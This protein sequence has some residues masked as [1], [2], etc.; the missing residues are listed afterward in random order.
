LDFLAATTFA[1]ALTQF[2]FVTV[3]HLYFYLS[4]AGNVR[5]IENA[6]IAVGGTMKKIACA[7]DFD[8]ADKV[9]FPGVGA[10]G[11]CMAKLESLGYVDCI[12]N[13]RHKRTRERDYSFFYCT[14]DSWSS[15]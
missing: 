5:S 11:S 9:I 8:L 7:T 12:R 2:H 15:I 6:V 13:V 1:R 4:G 10:F 3:V 14:R